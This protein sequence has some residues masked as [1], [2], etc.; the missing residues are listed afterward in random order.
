MATMAPGRFTLTLTSEQRAEL[1]R[2]RDTDPQGYVRERC[3]ALLQ[4]AERKTPDSIIRGRGLHSIKEWLSAYRK[5]GLAG[6]VLWQR[7]RAQL[8]GLRGHAKGHATPPALT[9]T[10]EEEQDLLRHRV[11]DP[12]PSV[13]ERCAVILMIGD[14]RTPHWV[15]KHGLVKP[16]HRDTV[17]AW[18]KLYKK[19]GLPRLLQLKGSGRGSRGGR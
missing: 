16:R 13:R 11:G 9:L 12:D 18:L 8:E 17:Y 1:V 2:C 19:A 5:E 6:L 15:A 14:G 7:Q 3:C 4:V 10:R